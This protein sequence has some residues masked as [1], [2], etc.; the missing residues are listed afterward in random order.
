MNHTSGGMRINL[1]QLCEL[2]TEKGK[3]EGM[4]EMSD[5][6]AVDTCI[7]CCLLCSRKSVSID[8]I[9]AVGSLTSSAQLEVK[10]NNSCYYN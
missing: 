10:K 4:Q 3:K 6:V 2:F 9:S 1:S 5:D 7:G 8:V